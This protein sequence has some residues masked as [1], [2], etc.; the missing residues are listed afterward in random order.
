MKKF[1]KFVCI[2]VL[3][4]AAL[5]AARLVNDKIILNN[6][7]IRLHVVA[8]SDSDEDQ[9]IK[10]LVK[11]EIVSFLQLQMVDVNTANEAEA[12]LKENLKNIEQLANNIL[13]QLNSKHTAKISLKKEAFDKRKYDTFSLPAGVYES[14]RVEIGESQGRNWWCVVFPSLCIPATA[15]GF[16]DTAVSSGFDG[17][18]AETLSGDERYEIRFYFLDCIG[19][20]EN[21]FFFH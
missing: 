14:L 6:H 13:A 1:A 7:L 16:Y 20:I 17:G 3:I 8:N 10:L 5:V 15:D 12:F 18:L 11:D 9:E 21:F 19:K 2:I 4:C